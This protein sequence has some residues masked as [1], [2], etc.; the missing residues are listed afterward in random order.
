MVIKPLMTR[1]VKPNYA[2]ELMYRK[3]LMAMVDEMQRSVL[4]W[5]R[6]R[7]KS[8][9]PEIIQDSAKPLWVRVYRY[10]SDASPSRD[11]EKELKKV[12]RRWKRRFDDMS[13]DIARNFVKQNNTASTA[14]MIAAL[15]AKGF[16][17]TLK[18]TYLTN[19]VLQS[20][21]IENTN[22]IKSI[23]QQYFTEV[24]GLVMR[25]IRGGR[26]MGFL[27]E[28]LEKR[29]DITKNRAITISRDQTNKATESITRARNVALG[30]KKGVWIH[31][32]GSKHPR[33]THMAMNGQEFYLSD[34]P[35]SGIE[36][37][38]FDADVGYNI[39]PAE[40]VNCKCT[41]S[42]VIPMFGA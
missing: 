25:S 14:S 29:Y 10:V 23:P 18:N 27:T 33:E 1:A 28:Q 32:G 39:L 30:V 13:E 24:Q 26:D 37:G 36:K 22:L 42:P 7:Y 19:D 21:I 5:I 40:L 17:L 9:L 12:M 20:L 38:L 3:K 16:A 8:R 31:I 15:K 6:A 2:I 41:Y 35:E 4:W 11:L 34:D